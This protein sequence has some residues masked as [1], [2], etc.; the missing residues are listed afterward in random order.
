MSVG[1]GSPAAEQQG[2]NAYPWDNSNQPEVAH[3]LLAM[4]AGGNSGGDLPWSG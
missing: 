4:E 3:I 2:T 1:G